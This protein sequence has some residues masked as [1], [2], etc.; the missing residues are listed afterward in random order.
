MMRLKPKLGGDWDKA[1]ARRHG[2]LEPD[3]ANVG[4]PPVF[5]TGHQTS[6]ELGVCVLRHEDTAIG[7]RL[8]VQH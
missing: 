3:A 2:E 6:S 7:V 1:R 4:T 8:G 5:Q